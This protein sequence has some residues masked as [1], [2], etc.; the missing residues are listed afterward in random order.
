MFY[1]YIQQ[2]GNVQRSARNQKNGPAVPVAK[3][4][5]GQSS[6]KQYKIV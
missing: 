1:I 5:K 6:Q 2:I 3:A 4:E